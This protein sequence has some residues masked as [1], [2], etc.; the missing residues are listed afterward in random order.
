MNINPTTLLVVKLEAQQ[1][2]VVIAGLN[3]LPLKHSMQVFQILIE[4]LQG[5][6]PPANGIDHHPPLA[7]GESQ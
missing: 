5:Q 1:W 7:Q 2:N 6:A 3:E 4:Q